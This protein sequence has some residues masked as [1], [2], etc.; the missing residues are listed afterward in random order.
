MQTESGT[1][2]AAA[3]KAAAN[4]AYADKAAFDKPAAGKAEADKTAPDKA[5]ADEMDRQ[6]WVHGLLCTSRQCR[7]AARRHVIYRSHPATATDLR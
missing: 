7:G 2:R 4:N 5:V 6:S 3:D 1:D